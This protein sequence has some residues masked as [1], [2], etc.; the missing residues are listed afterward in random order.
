MAR[1]KHKNICNRKQYNL[2]SSEPSC[3]STA[4]PG[5]PHIREKQDSYLKS[6]LMKMIE[7]LKEDVIVLLKK[8]RRL[9]IN[10]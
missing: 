6:Y 1:G 9:Q 4:S 5:Y 8:Y 10:R 7:D 2:A 3:P